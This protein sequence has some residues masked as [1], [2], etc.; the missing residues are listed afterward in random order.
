MARI[1]SRQVGGSVIA[2]MALSTNFATPVAF[3]DVTDAGAAGAVWQ[4]VVPANSGPITVGIDAVMLSIATGTNASGSSFNHQVKVLDEANAPVAHGELKI[5]S[6][7]AT[8][9]TWAASIRTTDDVIPNNASQ[10]TYR[11]QSQCTLVG[12]NSATAAINTSSGGVTR[13]PRLVARR[14]V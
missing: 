12:T 9:Q 3:A 2:S 1:G 4:V 8:A 10:K 13:D 6:S 5:Y 14:A 7:A 11:V